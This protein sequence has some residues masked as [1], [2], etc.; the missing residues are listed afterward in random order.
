[1]K[2]EKQNNKRRVDD[3]YTAADTLAIHVDK[4]FNTSS[5]VAPPIYQTSTFRAD[6]NEEFAKMALEPRHDQFYTRYG[7]PTLTQAGAVVAALEGAET[8]LL[9]AS[10]M[11][12]IST[13]VLTFVGQG[14]HVVAQQTHYGGTTS[15]LRDLLP[16][17]GVEV[18][19][20][21]QTLT[22]EFENALRPHTKLIVV[23]TP[24]NPLML[25][26][27]LRAI[28][29]I[30]RP[31]G[32]LTL[33]DNTF[34]TPINQRP[35]DLGIDL[36]AHSGTKYM[37]GHSDLSAGAVVGSAIL[38]E[39]IWNTSLML[40]SVLGPFDGWLLLRGLRTLPLRVER[41]NQTAL[42]VATFLETH[43]KVAR[44]YYPGLESHPQHDLARRQMN[45]FTGILSFELKGGLSAAKRLVTGV[46]LA[47]YA[48]SVGGTESLIVCPAIMLGHQ[49]SEEQF[50]KVGVR[51]GLV[52]LSVG[53]ENERDLISDLDQALAAA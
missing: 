26:T 34:A 28:A 3:T 21:D 13:S 27:D 22:S 35:L 20:V 53:L 41:H 47:S 30:A 38:L 51:P 49:M 46:R 11:G 18:T 16:R 14:D 52:R 32:I 15:L 33:A 5:A 7:N 42:A 44:V 12:A 6:S 36:V 25:L 2:S 4:K 37:G 9:T 8:A 48:A 39:K 29:G 1:M 17:Y 10:G 19:F 24:S 43:S 31:R 50:E 40:G 45:G 23:E